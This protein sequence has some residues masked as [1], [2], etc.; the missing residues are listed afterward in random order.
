MESTRGA[1]D[2]ISVFEVLNETRGELYVGA[3]WRLK[4]LDDFN[5]MT[6]PRAVRHWKAG[7]AL[8]FRTIEY[9]LPQAD[10]PVFIERYRTSDLV[11]SWKVLT[12]A[13]PG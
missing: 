3:T 12:D 10:A 13:Q 9:G 11:K 8:R 5:R 4:D 7:E 1:A 2:L 6:P